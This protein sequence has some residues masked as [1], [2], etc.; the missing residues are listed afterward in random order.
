MAKDIPEEEAADENG[1]EEPTKDTNV[2]I[3]QFYQ[4]F[5]YIRGFFRI[6]IK[7]K[8]CGR[9]IKTNISNALAFRVKMLA[10]IKCLINTR[11]QANRLISVTQIS[12]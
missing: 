10:S 2:C 6:I 8:S 12:K 1:Q 7:R 11:V 5:N 3:D 9:L 4:L